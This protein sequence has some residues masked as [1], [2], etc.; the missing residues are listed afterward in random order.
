MELA[1]F[2]LLCAGFSAFLANSKGRSGFNWFCLGVLCGPFAL[3]VGLTPVYVP[4]PKEQ[5]ESKDGELW[6]IVTRSGLVISFTVMILGA[7]N[8]SLP[9]ILLGLLMFGG[10]LFGIMQGKEKTDRLH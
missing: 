2:W 6:W 4:K 5:Q 10:C 8:E 1:I 3:L 9:I 7:A